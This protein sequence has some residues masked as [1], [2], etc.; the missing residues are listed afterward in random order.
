MR[1][2]EQKATRQVMKKVTHREL[3]GMMFPVFENGNAR[4]G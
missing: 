3:C 4:T 2:S 1:L